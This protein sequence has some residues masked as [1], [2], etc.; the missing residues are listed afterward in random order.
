MTINA[1]TCDQYP[2]L[3]NLWQQA[4]GDTPEF[5]QGFF[6]T[7]FAPK[8][9]R[10][11]TL[12]GAV[13]SALYWFDCD[14]GGETWAYIYAV[15]TDVAHRGKGLCPQLMED[16]HR[17]LRENGYAGAVLVPAEE[18]LWRYYGKMGYAPFGGITSTTMSPQGA[19]AALQKISPD[20]Y[21][22]AR[23]PYLPADALDQSS[24][25]PFYHT[26]GSFY[27]SE[28][29]CFAAAKDENTLYFQEFF[30]NEAAIP[31]ILSALAAEKGHVRLPGNQPCGMYLSFRGKVPCYLGFP[32]D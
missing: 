13:A 24:A 20:A 22:V 17:L 5:I 15:A 9:C 2:Q 21:Q 10:C 8:R 31:G 16:T 1:P 28:G 3:Q 30:G 11:I 6:R 23:A 25:Y 19:P 26:W 29:C 32:L 18:H 27:Q 4:F 12:D 7:G 14:F